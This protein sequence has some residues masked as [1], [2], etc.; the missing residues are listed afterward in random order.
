M[1]WVKPE[2]LPLTVYSTISK[3]PYRKKLQEIAID[4]Y[5]RIVAAQG[6]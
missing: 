3:L 6:K 5:L 1:G 2:V 4:S